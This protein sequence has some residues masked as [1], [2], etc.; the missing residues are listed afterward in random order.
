MKNKMKTTVQIM[1]AAALIFTACKKKEKE[2]TNNP[3]TPTTTTGAPVVVRTMTSSVNNVNWTAHSDAYSFS[4]SNSIY[5]FGGQTD[6]SQNPNTAI[7]F[8]LPR[9]ISVGTYTFSNS[10]SVLAYY[11]D[12]NG[13]FY[14]SNAGFINVTQIDTVSP[15]AGTVAKFKATFSF[16]TDAVVNQS[17]TV[18]NGVIDYNK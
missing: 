1:L 9:P 14:T 12:A 3:T 5:I 8:S 18:S 17:Y 2:N 16:T 13:Q 4:A 7:S 10:G 6:F 15:S 11:K